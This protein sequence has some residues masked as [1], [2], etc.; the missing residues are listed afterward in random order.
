M[1]ANVAKLNAMG[2]CLVSVVGANISNASTWRTLITLANKSKIPQLVYITL[3]RAN[4]TPRNFERLFDEM[5]AI[6]DQLNMLSASVRS[7]ASTEHG[8]LDIGCSS[9]PTRPQCQPC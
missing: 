7:I 8:F 4:Q 5:K 3:I 2:K 6:Q 9:H 1:N